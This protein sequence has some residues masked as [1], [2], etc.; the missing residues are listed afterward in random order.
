MS[1][2]RDGGV[3]SDYE[4]GWGVGSEYEE[5]WGLVVVSTCMRRDGGW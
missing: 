2:T 3:G 4:E 5:G 1:V